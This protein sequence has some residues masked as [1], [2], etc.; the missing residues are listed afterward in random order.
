[1]GKW[2]VDGTSKPGILMLRLEGAI[3]EGEMREFVVAHNAAIDAY[4]GSDY[5]VF[6][7]LRT[8]APLGPA[9]A[10]VMEKAKSYSSAHKSFRGSAVCVDSSLV[11]LQHQR[12]SVSGGVMDTELISDNVDRC[13]AHLASVQRGR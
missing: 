12:T 1:M 7:D 9:A 5:R 3:S 6:C 4:R 2:N 10:E 8:M 13:W 11:A